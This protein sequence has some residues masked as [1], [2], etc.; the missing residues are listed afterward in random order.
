MN[1]ILKKKKKC[2]NFALIM[3]ANPGF[4]S[5]SRSIVRYC[6]LLDPDPD[7][8]WDQCGPKALTKSIC[9]CIDLVPTP[10]AP[11]SKLDCGDTQEDR[12][13]ETTY[14]RKRG[15]KRVDKEPNSNPQEI[16]S[17][18]NHSK[19]SGVGQTIV[20]IISCSW[21]SYPQ[22]HSCQGSE[23]ISRNSTVLFPIL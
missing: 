6:K 12:E 7:M 13:R 17:S 4:R 2:Q 23:E 14:W 9:V 11:V 15:R 8:L 21:K 22:E 20:W 18:I 10:I 16:W 1:R 19:L 5:G 3:I